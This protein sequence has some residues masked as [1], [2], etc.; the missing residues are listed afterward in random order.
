VVNPN[1]NL[2]IGD[3]INMVYIKN[4][5]KYFKGQPSID[6]INS[7]Y[8]IVGNILHNI[9]PNGTYTM[10]VTLFRDGLNLNDRV[11]EKLGLYE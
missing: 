9:V 8:Y 1:F 3:K 7:G 6:E 5:D 10:I 2:N 11:N 4:V